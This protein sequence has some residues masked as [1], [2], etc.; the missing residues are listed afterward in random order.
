[1]VGQIKGRPVGIAGAMFFACFAAAMS[2][3]GR[4]AGPGVASETSIRKDMDSRIE[5]LAPDPASRTSPSSADGDK[6][7]DLS[8][9]SVHEPAVPAEMTED[10][11]TAIFLWMEDDLSHRQVSRSPGDAQV[12]SVDAPPASPTADRNSDITSDP[13]RIGAL[14]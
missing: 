3:N 5:R 4:A 2:V 7:V 1:M 9:R 6:M 12:A 14:Y 13:T 8:P 10:E 11:L